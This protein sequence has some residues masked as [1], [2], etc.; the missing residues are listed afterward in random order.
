MRSKID[1]KDGKFENLICNI[2][3]LEEEDP[4]KNR[5]GNIRRNKLN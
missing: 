3:T 1:Y 2:V 5:K 4:D